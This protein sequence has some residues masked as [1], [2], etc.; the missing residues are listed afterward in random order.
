MSI[1]QLGP[2]G[3]WAQSREVMGAGG[4]GALY[5]SA[6]PQGPARTRP[7]T[8]ASLGPSHPCPP[9]L[10]ENMVPRTFQPQYAWVG[11]PACTRGS[12]LVSGGPGLGTVELAGRRGRAAMLTLSYLLARCVGAVQQ[13]VGRQRQVWAG[14]RPPWGAWGCGWHPRAP[15]V[16]SR[17]LG[18]EVVAGTN[19]FPL[20]PRF[21]S[22]RAGTR[23]GPQ[24]HQL[25]T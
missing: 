23:P 4:G 15:R 9:H 22:F 3:S 20:S 7:Q 6:P 16:G 8:R 21:C 10:L 13:A 1:Q 19:P 12:C 17:A 14:A 25:R 2:A 11:G 5:R 24:G 18:R